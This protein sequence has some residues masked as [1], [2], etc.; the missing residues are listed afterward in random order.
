MT[1]YPWLHAPRRSLFGMGLAVLREILL[2]SRSGIHLSC[3][4]YFADFRQVDRDAPVDSSFY[5]GL[6]VVARKV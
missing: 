4:R 1:L 2:R 6:F 5:I 3:D